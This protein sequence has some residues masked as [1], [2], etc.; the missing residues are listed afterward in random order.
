[1][2][3]IQN[4]SHPMNTGRKMSTKE[5]KNVY[6]GRDAVPSYTDTCLDYYGKC[7]EYGTACLATMYNSNGFP[8]FNQLGRCEFQYGVPDCY[9]KAII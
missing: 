6:G 7:L 1:M 3:T 4:S 5:L 8:V 2:E 9:C